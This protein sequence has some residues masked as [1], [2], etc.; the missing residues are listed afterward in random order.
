MNNKKSLIIIAVM[1]IVPMLAVLAELQWHYV[2]HIIG[3]YLESHN[4]ERERLERFVQQE[5]QT[6]QALEDVNRLV[7]I[8][9]QEAQS[10]QEDP[11][12]EAGP[13]EI[14]SDTVKL[15]HGQKLIMT[16]ALF[17]EVQKKL[18]RTEY[19]I[20]RMTQLS[21]SAFL[22]DWTRTILVRPGW[23]QAGEVFFV[24]D[25]NYILY[26]MPLTVE[27]FDRIDSYAMNADTPF[28][29]DVKRIYMPARFFAMLRGL[30][31]ETRDQ[32]INP[33][34]FLELEATAK[35][36]GI[37]DAKRRIYIERIIGGQVG[38][39]P[40]PVSAELLQQ[41]NLALGEA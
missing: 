21:K 36:I 33:Y 9:S 24:D 6:S 35:R 41:I 4:A 16:R 22:N 17:M 37:S 30:P 25:D 28:E 23:L 31:S 10:L 29:D 8:R 5:I 1:C 3:G 39:I 11:E 18:R 34:Q 27:Q 2:E 15:D 13:P 26:R 14:R 12:E 19:A 7:Q 32:I 38:I 20:P 40:I